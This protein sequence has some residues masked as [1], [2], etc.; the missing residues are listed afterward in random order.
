M[1]DLENKPRNF[2]QEIIDKDLEENKNNGRV[3]TRFPLNQMG[4]C[5]LV[6]QNR[7]A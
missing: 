6:M 1:N 7:Y 5:I 3:L 2:I 4:I